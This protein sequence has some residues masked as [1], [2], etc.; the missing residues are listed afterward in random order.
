MHNQEFVLMP[1]EDLAWLLGSDDLNVV[2][3]EVVF[4]SVLDWIKYDL[5][6]RKKHIA[7]LLALV[8]LPLLSPQVQ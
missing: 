8:R 3:E 5:T 6:D 1:L 7:R 4:N 2:S